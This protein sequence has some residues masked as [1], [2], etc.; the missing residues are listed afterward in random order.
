MVLKKNR[1]SDFRAKIGARLS[2]R[3]IYGIQLHD[4]PT[5]DRP[6][7]AGPPF[8]GEHDGGL[9]AA[10]ATLAALF[11]QGLTWQGQHVD[12]SKQESLIAL[13][14]LENMLYANREKQE[15]REMVKA[16]AQ[17]AGMIGGLM[18]CRDGYV[19]LAAMQDN[20]WSGLVELMG[21]PAWTED[22]ICR[23][24]ETR[25]LN[26]QKITSL[27]E[28]WMMSQAKEEVFR[29]GQEKGVP[30]GAVN[31]PQDLVSSPQLRARGFFAEIEHPE[32]GRVEYTTAAYRFSKTPWSAQRPAPLL[33]E[34]NERIYCGLLGYSMQELLKMRQA[35]VI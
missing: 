15:T 20:Q 9:S 3:A 24:E 7:V 25:S 4:S 6:P 34:H 33:G 18:R 8:M 10:T 30:V 11:Y 13:S 17:G 12:V 2:R 29:S 31:S 23:S 21:H 35:G 28:E 16:S 22:E 5:P 19:V 27:V 1:M 32:A 26:A 14:R